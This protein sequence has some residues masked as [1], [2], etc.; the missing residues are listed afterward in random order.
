MHIVK[1]FVF[2]F[3]VSKEMPGKL[4]PIVIVIVAITFLYLYVNVICY[5]QVHQGHVRSDISL[6]IFCFVIML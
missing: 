6:S 4:L 3:F 1:K 2:K 5:F